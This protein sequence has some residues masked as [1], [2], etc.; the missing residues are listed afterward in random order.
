MEIV[1]SNIV[2]YPSTEQWMHAYREYHRPYVASVFVDYCYH[3]YYNYDT[4]LSQFRDVIQVIG[5]S[6]S[7]W[8]AE[9]IESYLDAI[10]YDEGEPPYHFFAFRDKWCLAAFTDGGT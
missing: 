3:G 9:N 5:S 2:V 6:N 7:S 8:Y 10:A 1:I 4:F